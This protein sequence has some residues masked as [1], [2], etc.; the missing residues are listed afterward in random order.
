MTAL[1]RKEDA[2]KVAAALD[3]YRF[4][5]DAE[6]AYRAGYKEDRT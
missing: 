2:A 4:Y 1:I 3:A 5:I 6:I